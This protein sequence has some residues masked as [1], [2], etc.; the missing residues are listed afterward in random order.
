MMFFSKKKKKEL[1]VI[2]NKLMVKISGKPRYFMFYVENNNS[3][4]LDITDVEKIAFYDD[5]TE[6]IWREPNKSEIARCIRLGLEPHPKFTNGN[7][8]EALQTMTLELSKFN[9]IPRLLH[10]MDV[11]ISDGTSEQQ[12]A[13]REFQY[14]LGQLEMEAREI[15]KGGEK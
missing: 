4:C 11:F 8:T 3:Y 14:K 15:L 1:A 9:H 12:K 2:Q 10:D 13:W 7:K 6:I 5:K